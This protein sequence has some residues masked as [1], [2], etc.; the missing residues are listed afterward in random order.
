M[1]LQQR[2]CVYPEKNL[3]VSMTEP[4]LDDAE[5]KVVLR[6]PQGMYHIDVSVRF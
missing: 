2:N 1:A 5:Q 3:I 6:I 4:A